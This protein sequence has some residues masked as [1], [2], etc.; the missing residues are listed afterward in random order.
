MGFT[1]S[2]EWENRQQRDTKSSK[3]PWIGCLTVVM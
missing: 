2:Q 1:I 3:Y